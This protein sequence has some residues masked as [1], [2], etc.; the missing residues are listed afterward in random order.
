MF[1]K[2][3]ERGYLRSCF[4]RF[5]LKGHFGNVHFLMRIPERLFSECFFFVLRFFFLGGF[6]FTR[7]FFFLERALIQNGFLFRRGDLIRMVFVQRIVLKVFFLPGF[8]SKSVLFLKF[9]FL[10]GW[11]F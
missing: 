11:F 5:F 3:F 4:R 2:K 8:C 1:Q 9:L 7:F 6:F 10:K